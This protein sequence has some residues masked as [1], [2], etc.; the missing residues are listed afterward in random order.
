MA[1]TGKWREAIN[2]NQDILYYFPEDVEALNRF[3]KAHLEMGEYS[4]ARDA[5]QKVLDL[6]PH[7]SIAKRNLNRLSNLP[8]THSVAQEGKKVIPHLFLEDVGKSGITRLRNPA[9]TE[10][11]AKVAAGDSVPLET[12]NNTLVVKSLDGDDLGY[13]EPKLGRRLVRLMGQ[14]NRYDAVVQS[15]GQDL[16]SVIIREAYKD[17]SLL[18][19]QSFPALGADEHRSYVRDILLRYDIDSDPEEES[20]GDPMAMWTEDGDEV[21]VA[22]SR[23][24]RRTMSSDDEDGDE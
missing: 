24:F 5:F 17:P 22:T 21:S 18:G 4:Q 2:V 1:L 8:G 14:G 7:N 6:S 20:D 19:V 9:S 3:G 11:L 10:V 15:A 12:H 23:G 13:V 16:I